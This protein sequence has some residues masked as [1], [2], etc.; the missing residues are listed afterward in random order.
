[1]LFANIS[2][3][4]FGHGGKLFSTWLD[5]CLGLMVA[6]GYFVAQHLEARTGEP[7]GYFKAFLNNHRVGMAI[8]IGLALDYSLQY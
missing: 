3:N 4:Y 5:L 7:E 8:F 6:A 1:M 2:A